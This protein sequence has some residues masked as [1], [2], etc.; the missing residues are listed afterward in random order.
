MLFMVVEHYEQ[1]AR[2][3]YERFRDQGRSAPEGIRYVDSWVAAA[4]DRC[5]QLMECD[6]ISLLQ[7]WVAAWED[8]VRFEIVPVTSSADASSVFL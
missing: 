8:L 3:V 4:L 1:G 5:F 2:R 6:D 7:R